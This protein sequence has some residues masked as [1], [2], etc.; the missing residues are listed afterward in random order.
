MGNFLASLHSIEA[1]RSAVLRDKAP[2]LLPLLR[3]GVRTLK[4]GWVLLKDRLR[5]SPLA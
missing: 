5:A 2:R 1:E 3:A 4:V